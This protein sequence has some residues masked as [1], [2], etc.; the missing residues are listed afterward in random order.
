MRPYKCTLCPY[1]A[2]QEKN[3]RRHI[4]AVHEKLKPFQ[5]NHCSYAS[6]GKAQL[7]GHIED[8][9]HGVR[10]F[11]CAKPISIYVMILI[12]ESALI[13]D[14]H[15]EAMKQLAQLKCYTERRK[16]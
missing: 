8:H 2:T 13:N 14:V 12:Y 5:C 15:Y 11:K 9:H 4:N 10:K 16:K 7:Q 3:L 6:A 1:A